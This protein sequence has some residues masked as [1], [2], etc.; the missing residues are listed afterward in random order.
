MIIDAIERNRYHVLVGSD[1]VFMD[2]A[3]RI[4][5]RYAAKL[6]SSQMQSLL[7]E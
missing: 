1:A 4:T 7:P 3:Y 2:L 6:I 5:P